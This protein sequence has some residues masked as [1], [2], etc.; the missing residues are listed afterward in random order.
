[1]ALS[2]Y[3]LTSAD[4]AGGNLP[5][6]LNG[7]Q[8]MVDGSPAPLFYVSATQVNFLM[9]PN[10]I[11]GPVTVWVVLNS[12]AGPQVSLTL[13]DAAPAL[14]PSPLDAG[15]AIAQLWPAYTSIA[16]A[17]PAAPGGIV[18]LYATGLGVTEPNPAL[19]TEIPLYAGSI[20]R[21]ADLEVLLDGTPLDP[22]QVLYAGIC[23]G[24]AGLYQI[25]FV[26]PA[27]VGPNPE[28]RVGIGTQISPAGLVLAVQ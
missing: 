12:I 19:P 14:F 25:D 18:I 21:M 24:W 11:A 13:E 8:V 27:N 15:Y 22:A 7:V 16:P 10:Q 3:S 9:P 5:T 20:E 4:I 23:P 17:S 1:M 28:I 6:I 26:L 2:A